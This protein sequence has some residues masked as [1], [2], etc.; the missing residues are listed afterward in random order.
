MIIEKYF[1][2]KTMSVHLREDACPIAKKGFPGN[3]DMVKL[4]TEKLTEDEVRNIAEEI[5]NYTEHME[6]SFLEIERAGSTIIQLGM[7]RIVITKKPFSDGLEITAVKPVAK[8]NIEDYKLDEK[9]KERLTKQA[10]GILISGSPG[11]GKTTL[12]RALAEHLS[13]T[14]RIVKT[15]ESPRDMLLSSE[16]TQY[17]L[18]HGERGEIH[19]V[20]LLSRP[21]NTFFDEMRNNDD[22]E[23]FADLRLAGIGMVGIVHATNPIDSIQRF[24]GKI[25]MGIIPQVIDTVVFVKHGIIEKVMELK[26]K[27]K[28]PT[29][30]TEADL[31]RPMIEVRDFS[32]GKL[33]F[34]IY[35]YGEHTVVIP[36]EKK[37]K[38]A[39][40][41]L[42]ADKIS[43][44]F[45][46]YSKE[47]QVE[48]IS[49]HR[50]KVYLPNNVISKVIGEKGK[51]IEKIEKELGVS[52]DVN[53]LSKEMTRKKG[54]NVDYEV[55][56][57][58]KNILINLDK[59][60]KDKEI[61]VYDDEDLIMQ[62]HSSKK[63]VIKLNRKS[64][65]GKVVE[66]A[67]KNGTLNVKKN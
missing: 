43:E 39:S 3:W 35:S 64:A 42:A 31:A 44:Y 62:A 11:E 67:V 21:D 59:R 66:K 6:K 52:I 26:M 14:G 33:D 40:W 55:D 9:L 20:L 47:N 29:G 48:F 1:D 4:G 22:F 2:E 7:Y 8:L 45:K 25:E 15:V 54:K 46:K 19:D 28:V 65:L 41:E 58:K 18:N 38:K 23:L 61:N 27:V 32:S 10:D 50:I 30:M 13:S 12:G 57:E 60:M 34:E 37:Q 49:D 16:I 5:V 24:I 36:V 63:A 51:Q 56:L 17:S 53:E